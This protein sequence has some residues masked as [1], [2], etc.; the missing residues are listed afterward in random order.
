MVGGQ[1]GQPGEGEVC[2]ILI[3]SKIEQTDSQPR[4]LSD[5]LNISNKLR[6]LCLFQV[7]KTP[8]VA[9]KCI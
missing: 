7:Y 8:P 4:Q 6:A 5:S 2:P 3:Y 9:S 1:D